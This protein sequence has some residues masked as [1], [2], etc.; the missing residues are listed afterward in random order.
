MDLLEEVKQHTVCKFTLILW[1]YC[2]VQFTC[3]SAA[4]FKSLHFT[5]PST[6]AHPSSLL[7]NLV[8]SGVDEC[9]KGTS[10]FPRIYYINHNNNIHE[11]SVRDCRRL[12]K[13]RDSSS[14]RPILTIFN[15]ASDVTSILSKRSKLSPPIVIKPD[16]SPA[17]RCQEATLLKQRWLLIQSG[18]NKKI[19]IRNNTLSKPEPSVM[20]N[21]SDFHTFPLTSV[22]GT[23]VNKRTCFSSFAY[24]S[25]YNIF[26]ITETWLSD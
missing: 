16:M 14:P 8:F 21:Y 6:T 23:L 13:Y 9:P 1:S 20:A 3:H 7:F 5:S 4:Q 26:S 15:R 2:P 10:R 18:T 24:S 12:G 25:H 17:E 11:Y 22:S 19:K